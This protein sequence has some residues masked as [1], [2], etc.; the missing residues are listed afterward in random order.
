MLRLLLIIGLVFAL[1]AALSAFLIAREEYQ[2]HQFAGRQL[3]HMSLQIA[4]TA[5]LFFLLLTL[6]GGYF[7]SRN[8]Q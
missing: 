4:L 3:F 2:K 6:V 1:L 7:V 8:S 5:F